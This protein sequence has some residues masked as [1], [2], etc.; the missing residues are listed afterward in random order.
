VRAA[1]LE[2]LDFP[3]GVIRARSCYQLLEHLDVLLGH[4]P[5]REVCKMCL[6]ANEL[7]SRLLRITQ[8]T[9][10]YPRKTRRVTVLEGV[11]M[12]ANGFDET[13]AARHDWNTTTSESFKGRDP[14]RFFPP[15]WDHKETLL[16]QSLR[17][18][19]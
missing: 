17:D 8:N 7:G 4:T 1:L 3:L 13:T 10:K 11:P 9:R 14:E 6:D 5:S 12:S 2:R 19:R 16:I 15:G 18:R